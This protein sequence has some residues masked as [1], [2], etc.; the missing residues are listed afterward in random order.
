MEEPERADIAWWRRVHR[1]IQR[2]INPKRRD[3][4][5]TED[6]E[7]CDRPTIAKVLERKILD[8]QTRDKQIYRLHIKHGYTLKEIADYLGVHYTTVSKAIKEVVDKNK[9]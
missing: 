6:A 7:I 8:K 4:R 9:N 1:E 5:D 2:F 3:K